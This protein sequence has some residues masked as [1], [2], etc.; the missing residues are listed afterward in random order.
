M[1][2]LRL[3]KIEEIENIPLY[4]SRKVDFSIIFKNT[5]VVCQSFSPLLFDWF[6]TIDIIGKIKANRKTN[7]LSHSKIKE[8][9]ISATDL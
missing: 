6:C 3:S 8:P 2:Y 4:Y 1:D 9:L 7:L 5:S